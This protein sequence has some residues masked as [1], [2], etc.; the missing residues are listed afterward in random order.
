MEVFPFRNKDKEGLGLVETWNS[1]VM[2]SSDHV[3]SA[4]TPIPNK[5]SN[6]FFFFLISHETEFVYLEIL[7]SV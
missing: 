6:L 4:L 7:K 2:G 3:K 1:H 5:T